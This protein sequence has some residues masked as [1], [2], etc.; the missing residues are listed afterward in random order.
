MGYVGVFLQFLFPRTAF[1]TTV[2]ESE[3]DMTR[4]DEELPLKSQLSR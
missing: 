4:V 1:L 3:S 2:S